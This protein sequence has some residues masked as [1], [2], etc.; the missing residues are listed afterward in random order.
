MEP[1]NRSH[2]IVGESKA[3]IALDQKYFWYK[4]FFSHIWYDMTWGMSY[5]I[6]VMSYKSHVMYYMTRLG[7]CHILRDNTRWLELYDMTWGMSYKCVMLYITW[8]DSGH[9]ISASGH[10][11]SV[12]HVIYYM[13][14]L[15]SCHILRDMTRWLELYAMTGVKSYKCVMLCIIWHAS[16]HATYSP[17]PRRRDSKWSSECKSKSSRVKVQVSFPMSHSKRD[18]W[19]PSRILFCIPMTI[20]SLIFAGTG[21]SR[22]DKIGAGGGIAFTVCHGGRKSLG[23]KNVYFCEKFRSWREIR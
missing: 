10:V 6:S 3:Q 4:L 22:G 8:Q 1:T 21:C 16:S 15:E 9:V 20:S 19:W 17:F 23:R 12:C 14:R 2:L 11:I 7:S 5:H 13:T 18:L